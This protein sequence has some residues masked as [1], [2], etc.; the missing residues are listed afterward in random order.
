MCQAHIKPTSDSDCVCVGCVGGLIVVLPAVQEYYYLTRTFQTTF[1]SPLPDRHG[2]RAL[3]GGGGWGYWGRHGAGGVA[4]LHNCLGVT[5][6][7]ESWKVSS[8]PC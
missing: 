8:L 3:V 5:L 7:S 1:S 4:V 2:A 6:S